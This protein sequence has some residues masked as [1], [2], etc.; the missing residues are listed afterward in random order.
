MKRNRNIFLSL[1]KILALYTLVV[2]SGLVIKSCPGCAAGSDASVVKTCC[3]STSGSCA[4]DCTSDVVLVIKAETDVAPVLLTLDF[5]SQIAP[6]AP[7][8][9][10]YS[11][12]VSSES[13]KT[14]R[15]PLYFPDPDYQV[16]YQTFLC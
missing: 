12:Q 3:D 4:D 15:A 10:D 1:A 16:L 5:Q 11:P 6:L 9:L 8:V 7:V 2:F 13:T 14:Y